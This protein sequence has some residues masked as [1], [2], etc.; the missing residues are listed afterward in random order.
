MVIAVLRHGIVDV[1]DIFQHK[2]NQAMNF[3]RYGTAKRKSQRRIAAINAEVEDMERHNN[4]KK[5]MS[6][7][8]PK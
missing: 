2:L 5:P 8:V 3:I 4:A 1:E 7:V 6:D